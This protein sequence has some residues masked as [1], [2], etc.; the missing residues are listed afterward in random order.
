MTCST[1]S[2]NGRFLEKPQDFYL[3]EQGQL[4]DLIQKDRSPVGLLKLADFATR[5]PVKAPF[6]W[7]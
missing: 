5:G 1:K 2:L 4:S 6:S 7:P 3:Q